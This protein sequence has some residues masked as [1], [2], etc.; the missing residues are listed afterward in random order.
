M[1][2]SS[3]PFL[4]G[5]MPLYFIVYFLTPEKYRNTILLGGSLI[6]YAIGTKDQ[7]LYF[8]LLLLSMIIN[9]VLAQK[10]QANPE[11]KKLWL[12]VGIAYDF[13]LLFL[14]KYLGFFCDTLE[15]LLSI[16]LP[17]IHPALPPGIS[18][19][20][21][22]VVSYLADVYR[23]ASYDTHAVGRV[24]TYM[25]MYPQIISGPITTYDQVETSLKKRT[26]SPRLFD[27]GLREFCIGLGM[28]VILANQIGNLW[29]D[30]TAIGYESIST[31]L[32]WMGIAAFSMQLYLD[33]YSYSLMARGL[34]LMMGLRLPQNFRYPYMSLSMTDFWRR[35]HMSLGQWFRD[36]IYI[37][38]G[39]SREGKLRTY[40]N[41]LVVWLFTGLW[42]GAS[43]NFVLWGLLLFVLLSIERLGLK[44]I[45]ERIPLLG[46]LYMLFA[47]P[48]SWLV[49]A[50]SDLSQI[51]VYLGRLFPFLGGE[52]QYVYAQ[53]YI[54]YGKTYGVMLIVCFLFCTP[55]PRKLYQKYGRSLLVT[56]GLA[57]VFWLSVYLLHQ[58]L[59]DPFMYFRF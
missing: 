21:F 47:I 12:I 23:G 51:G 11:Q 41:M 15:L 44:K 27:C 19:F 29:N 46:H 50:I 38:L 39:G 36:Y 40:R 45:L 33:F 16:D 17:D 43:W 8:F 20:T 13:G 57:A 56:V 53:D 7:P 42:H 14:F 58:G 28:K 34:G 22:Q 30:V 55:L 25:S 2:F 59:N 9:I 10:I 31:P 5:F 1:V 18:F 35:W 54:K 48:L 6:F 49:F 3:L 26:H 52:A 4:F 37:P 32:A 24:A